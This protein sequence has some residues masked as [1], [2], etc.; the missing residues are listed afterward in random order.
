MIVI[1]LIYSNGSEQTQMRMWWTTN[2]CCFSL[3]HWWDFNNKMDV[4]KRGGAATSTTRWTIVQSK[5]RRWIQYSSTHS[6]PA[7]ATLLDCVPRLRPQ[8]RPWTTTPTISFAKTITCQIDNRMAA[9][10]K[11]FIANDNSI[12]WLFSKQAEI[13]LKT[14]LVRLW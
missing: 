2:W 13:N 6:T 12:C 10:L 9:F 5:P 3:A 14:L 7:T 1:S 8:P 4:V 11:K